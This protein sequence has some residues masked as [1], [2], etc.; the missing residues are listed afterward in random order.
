MMPNTPPLTIKSLAARIPDGASI[1]IPP[2]YSGCAMAA[3]A[4]LIQRRART[5]SSDESKHSKY[6]AIGHDQNRKFIPKWNYIGNRKKLPSEKMVYQCNRLPNLVFPR[7]TQIARIKFLAMEAILVSGSVHLRLF[8]C[9][10][11]H[12]AGSKCVG[13]S[14]VLGM[15]QR[16]NQPSCVD[17]W[18]QTATPDSPT[19]II[20]SSLFRMI[21][22]PSGGTTRP[23]S[24]TFCSMPR[25]KLEMAVSTEY[26]A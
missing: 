25:R 3:V 18:P 24:P 20:T 6:S 22:T 19:T 16:I 9:R 5:K 2:D 21:S 23:R 13:T 11:V 8:S 14:L 12:L 17:G 15:K 7:I 1:A 26:V 4:A 10:F